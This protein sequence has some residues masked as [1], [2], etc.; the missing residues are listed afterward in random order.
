M[1]TKPESLA[2]CLESPE[3]PAKST[4]TKLA[5]T[6]YEDSESYE[7]G[8]RTLATFVDDDNAVLGQRAIVKAV[9][10]VHDLLIAVTDHRFDLQSELGELMKD[11]K[12]AVGVGEAKLSIYKAPLSIVNLLI[13][14]YNLELEEL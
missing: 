3:P 13:G 4:P 14:K 7:P 12:K 1:E 8:M 11:I 10:Y 9:D 6:C 2:A 5:L